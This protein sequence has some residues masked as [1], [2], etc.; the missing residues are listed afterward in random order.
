MIHSIMKNYNFD[1]KEAWMWMWPEQ[2]EKAN[3]NLTQQVATK[4]NMQ[5]TVLCTEGMAAP[6]LIPRN[7]A[8]TTDVESL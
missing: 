7:H 1:G 8:G 5:G 4:A 6:E 2:S 3:I